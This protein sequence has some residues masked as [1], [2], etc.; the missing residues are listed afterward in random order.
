[1]DQHANCAELLAALPGCEVVA[2]VDLAARTVL[3]AEARHRLPQ[4][5]LD[6]L[7]DWAADMLG[8]ATAMAFALDATALTVAHRLPDHETGQAGCEALCLVLP[9]TC[10]PSRMLASVTTGTRR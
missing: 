9:P 1:M 8:D 7:C 10:D 4:E 2:H 3:K 5:Q 6:A